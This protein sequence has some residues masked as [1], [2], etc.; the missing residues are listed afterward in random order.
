LKRIELAA[1]HHETQLH[2]LPGFQGLA[3]C[4][5]AVAV[6]TVRKLP[7]RFADHRIDALAAADNPID[8]SVFQRV[9]TT[10]GPYLYQTFVIDR[11]A[12]QGVALGDVFAVYPVANKQ[13]SDDPSMVACAVQVGDKSSTLAIVKMFGNRLAPGDA[14]RLIRRIRF[15]QG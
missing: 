8:A 6:A 10:E 1:T 11:G 7:Q 15:K 2:R 3:Q 5:D 9:E 4:A 13:P 14:V 12:A